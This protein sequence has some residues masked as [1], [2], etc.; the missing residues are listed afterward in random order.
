MRKFV[1][2]EDE[3]KQI[4]TTCAQLPWHVAN[5]T[6]QLFDQIAAR[7]LPETTKEQAQEMAGQMNRLAR[8]AAKAQA[9]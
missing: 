7:A 5:P 9:K 3:L 8:R 1:V 4:A 2:T 6:M